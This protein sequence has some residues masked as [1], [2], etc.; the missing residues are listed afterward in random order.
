MLANQRRDFIG[1]L[2]NGKF[3]RKGNGEGHFFE[4]SKIKAK[5]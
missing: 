3:G 2:G 1:V 5:R 4:S